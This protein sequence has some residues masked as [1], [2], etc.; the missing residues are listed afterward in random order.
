MRAEGLL[1]L[2]CWCGGNQAGIIP[3]NHALL[4][5]G[6]NRAF[7]GLPAPFPRWEDLQD[8]PRAFLWSPLGIPAGMRT[9]AAELAQSHS[10]I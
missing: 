6:N 3:P 7:W 4:E 1:P 10:P 2:G 9:G 5:L 8:D